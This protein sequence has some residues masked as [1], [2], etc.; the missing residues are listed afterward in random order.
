MMLTG[1]LVDTNRFRN[2][3]GARTFEVA[4]MLKE[5]GADP[6]EGDML[7]KDEIDEFELKTKILNRAQYLDHGIVLVPYDEDKTISRTVMSQVADTLL[8]VKDVEATFVCAN[9]DQNLTA[10]SARSKGNVNVQ[11]IME[12]MEGGGHFSAAATQREDS[13]VS[14]LVEQL[15]QVIDD[16]FAQKE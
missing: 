12:A 16:Y 7:L 9:T 6:I 11:V 2:R 5:Y 4:S 8:N 10:I 13:S 3:T 1:I 14:E 15:L